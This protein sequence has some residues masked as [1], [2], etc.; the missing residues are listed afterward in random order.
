MC[1][2]S[3]NNNEKYEKEKKEKNY[4]CF[5]CPRMLGVADERG[6]VPKGVSF[7]VQNTI[8]LVISYSGLFEYKCSSFSV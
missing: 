7:F 2:Y 6:L 1:A 3:S 4:S 8:F 5:A